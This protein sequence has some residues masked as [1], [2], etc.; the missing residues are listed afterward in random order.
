MQ[1]KSQRWL[2]RGKERERGR[3][4]DVER[5]KIEGQWT[6]LALRSESSGALSLS[7]FGLLG[8]EGGWKWVEGKITM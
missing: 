5:S 1:F 7:L 8:C 3:K 6:E 4:R 2:V